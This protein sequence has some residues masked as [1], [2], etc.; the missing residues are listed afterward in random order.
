MQGRV[1]IVAGSDCSGG[2]GIQADIKTVTALNGYAMTAITALTAQNTTGVYGIQDVPPAFVKQQMELCLSDI[3]AD[4]VKTGMLH[5]PGIIIAIRE[6]LE[7]QKE[8]IPLVVDPV[9]YS[10]S[11]AALIEEDAIRQL[12]VDLMPRIT[13]L[14][15]NI[16]EAE[17]L[18]CMKINSIETMKHAAQMLLTMGPTAVL[19]KGGHFNTDPVIDV[20]A[21]EQD[22]VTFSQPRIKSQHTHGTGCTLASAIATGIAQG[23]ALTRAVQLAHSYMHEA[24]R[25][26]PGYGKGHG[27]LNHAWT[28]GDLQSKAA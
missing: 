1:L 7:Q 5:N 2:A 19:I 17:A 8:M 24:I 27:P 20:L 6:V 22:V 23:H 11:G 28:V 21:T 14:T 16:P 3:G 26:A 12:K 18:A 10:K 13:L 4:C 25:T 15:P 9:M